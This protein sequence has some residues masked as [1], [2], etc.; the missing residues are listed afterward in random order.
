M[1]SF[2]QGW[3]QPNIVAIVAFLVAIIAGWAVIRERVEQIPV[4]HRRVNGIE[5]RASEDHDCLVAVKVEVVNT[6]AML[7]KMDSKLD[8]LDTKLDAIRRQP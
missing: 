2:W 4:L 8:R 1:K 3:V 6:K 7:D 5:A